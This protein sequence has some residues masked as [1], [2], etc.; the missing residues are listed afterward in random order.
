MKTKIRKPD[1]TTGFT[2]KTWD[3][4]FQAIADARNAKRADARSQ[5]ACLVEKFT[6]KVHH[7]NTKGQMAKKPAGELQLARTKKS[8]MLAIQSW[9]EMNPGVPFTLVYEGW[10]D[11]TDCLWRYNEGERDERIVVYHVPV[12]HHAV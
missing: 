5:Y 3:A 11:G 4:T 9:A 10:F 1:L 8:I 7:Y 12:Y 6:F 2:H